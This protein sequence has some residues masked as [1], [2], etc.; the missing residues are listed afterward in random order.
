V[1]SA[2]LLLAL[3]ALGVAPALASEE[4]PT[5]AELEKELVCPTCNTTLDMSDSPQAQRMRV[6]IRERIE[7]GDSKSEIKAS[8]VEMLGEGVLAAPPRRGFDLLAWL[9]P[10]GGL[11]AASAAVGLLAWRWSSGRAPGDDDPWEAL[12]QPSTNGHAALDA[13][14]ERRL[15]EELA[16]FEP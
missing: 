12:E 11:V 13:E 4:R 10:L 1:R 15:D 9:L 8:L 7:A 5:L 3:L 14:L 6:F 2:A 16:R